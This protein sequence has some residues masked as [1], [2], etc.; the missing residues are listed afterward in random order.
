MGRTACTEPQ[1]LYKGVLYLYLYL[2]TGTVF[3]FSEKQWKCFMRMQTQIIPETK[4][5][6]VSLQ[7]TYNQAR[8]NTVH[9]VW[10][11]PL[12]VEKTSVASSCV[13]IVCV[14]FLMLCTASCYQSG[15]LHCLLR[16]S[17]CCTSVLCVGHRRLTAVS[18]SGQ[19]HICALLYL[20]KPFEDFLLHRH[21]NYFMVQKIR[22]KLFSDITTEIGYVPWNLRFL[23]SVTLKATFE[24]DV[25]SFI[26][27][28]WAPVFRGNVYVPSSG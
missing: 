6:N 3:D 17:L 21:N 19:S 8:W 10:T 27:D 18:I 15:L 28:I 1:C 9:L 4:R 13:Y 12:P 2:D 23:T 20:K 14:F 5:R 11:G 22:F 24:R 16:Y 7:M 25:T 26:S